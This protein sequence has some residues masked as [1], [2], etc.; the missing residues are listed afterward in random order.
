MTAPAK[1]PTQRYADA[2]E[3]ILRAAADMFLTSGYDISMDDLAARAGFSKATLYNHHASKRD[4]LE[5]VVGRLG[6]NFMNKLLFGEDDTLA[7]VLRRFADEFERQCLS[8]R[9]HQFFRLF[10]ADISRFPDLARDVYAATGG[11]AVAALTAEL[12]RLRDKG[13]IRAIDPLHTAERFFGALTGEARHRAFANTPLPEAE[14]RTFVEETIEMFG[15]WLK[16]R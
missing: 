16:L 9:G 1:R 7:M 13:A 11:R 14:R 3:L 5:A 4:L 2:E 6:E 15:D 10:A 12:Q 8:E